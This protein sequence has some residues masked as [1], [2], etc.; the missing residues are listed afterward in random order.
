VITQLRL[1]GLNRIAGLLD[2]EVTPYNIMGGLLANDPNMGDE[3]PEIIEIEQAN[4]TYARTD[5]S[6]DSAVSFVY[7][8]VLSDSTFGI[9]TTSTQGAIEQ[10][11]AAEPAI[12][13]ILETIALQFETPFPE[14]AFT[15]YNSYPQGTTE[16]GFPMLGDPDAPVTITEIGSFD[17][18]H[19]REFHDT[20][21]PELLPRIES[22]DV[23]FVFVPIYGTGN[24]PLGDSAARTALCVGPANFWAM[25]DVLFSWQDF[26]GF[27]FVYE[28]LQQGAANG[29]A[30]PPETFDACCTSDEINIVLDAAR[31]KT[32]DILGQQWATP[33]ILINDLPL[34]QVSV[35]VLMTQIDQVLAESGE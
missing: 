4:F 12:L 6:S 21:F 7:V 30:I 25:H 26:G 13:A 17:C 28:R 8:V 18:P 5:V 34:E 31:Q 24:I 22:G 29:V 15:R 14:G 27:A 35:D 3:L 20:I 10:L 2:D 16:E 9:I 23:N 32:F 33:T 11:E 1:F 19:C